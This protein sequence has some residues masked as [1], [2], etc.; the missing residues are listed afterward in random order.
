MMTV[1]ETCPRCGAGLPGELLDGLCESCLLR[2]S[3]GIGSPPPLSDDAAGAS[4]FDLLDP[5]LPETARVF[6]DYELLE[7]L[8]AGGMGIVWRARQRT[9]NRFVAIKMIRAGQLARPEDVARF[10]NEAEAVARLRHP[11]IVAIHEVGEVDAQH[12]FSMDLAPGLSLSQLLHD[13]PLMPR[14]AATILQRLCLAIQHAHERGVIHRDLK[15][16]NILLDDHDQPHITDF[17]L[18]RLAE[19]ASD[20]TRTDAIVGS[21]GYMAPEQAAGRNRDVDARTDL[22]AL[23][24]IL[25]ELLTGRPPYQAGSAMAT[26]K[27]VVESEPVPPRL[28]NPILPRDLDTI[29]LK[30]LEKEPAKRYPTAQALADDLEHF[31]NDESILARPVTR[32]ERAARWCRR[33]P[34][35]AS[36]S[37]LILLLLV[38]VIVGSPIAAYRINEARRQAT[39]EADTARAMLSFLRDDLLSVA[40]PFAGNTE[41]PR[42]RN[43]TLL[44]AVDL[45]ARNVRQRF[46]D[47]PLVEAGIR[48]TLW[49]VYFALGD[50]DRAEEH[51]QSAL[52]LYNQSPGAPELERLKALESMAWMHHARGRY[53]EAT[54]LIEPVLERR[55]RLQGAD[56]PEVLSAQRCRLAILSSSSR[57]P[58]AIA[59]G[60]DLLERARQLPVEHTEVL[61]R[62]MT[63]MSWMEYIDGDFPRCHALAE[64]AL[65]IARSRLGEGH[66][67]TLELKFGWA[68]WL[69]LHLGRVY[70]AT[71]LQQEAYDRAREILGETHELTLNSLSELAWLADAKG[72]FGRKM[73]IQE[74]LVPLARQA[75]G[76]D[77]PNAIFE[78]MRLGWGR[79]EE[80]RLDDADAVLTQAL[81]GLR[82]SRGSDD[83]LARRAMRWLS[84][85]HIARAS[86]PEAITLRKA[87]LELERRVTGLDAPWTHFET[88]HLA[89]LHARLGQWP[90]SAKLFREFLPNWDPA[91]QRGRKRDSLH[92]AGYVTACLAGDSIIAREIAA[93]ALQRVERNEDW[94]TRYEIALAL[95]LAPQFVTAHS[96]LLTL[97]SSLIESSSD[98]RE[99]DLLAAVLAYRQSEFDRSAILL[100]AIADNTSTAGGLASAFLSMAHHRLGIDTALDECN[101]AREFVE[102]LTRAGELGHSIF[103]PEEEWLPAA[104]LILAGREAEI[105][106]HG[107]PIQPQFDEFTMANA[108][109]R[110]L[111][112]RTLLDDV[113]RAANRGDWP[114][115]LEPF[116]AAIDQEYFDW[117]A[118]AQSREHFAAKAAALLA[119]DGKLN[120][121]PE[122]SGRILHSSH[123]AGSLNGRMFLLLQ[124]ESL[125]PTTI[126]SLVTAARAAAQDGQEVDGGNPWWSLELGLAELRAGNPQAALNALEPAVATY[127]LRCAAAAHAVAALAYWQL[128]DPDLARQRLVQART[129]YQELSSG[130]RQSLGNRWHEIIGVHLALQ[131]ATEVLG[132]GGQ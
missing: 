41:R 36:A 52:D 6:G 90:E 129:T 83:F 89:N 75:F 73:E 78:Q 74:S 11:G 96:E 18:A 19:N 94:Q 65:G 84:G 97:A 79:L 60:E 34:A 82:K 13:G 28:L 25:Y 132:W 120:A 81:D 109:E 15:P 118:A 8:G 40:D 51:I 95:L 30:C 107:Q 27:L 39:Q 20:L 47:Q 55:T 76:P 45:A 29:C 88:Y 98:S 62:I 31:L 53:A 124:D 92:P 14:R 24:A 17:G 125:S 63:D 77:S 105:F 56:H 32:V 4:L 117:S 44:A 122:L 49:Q 37:L 113:D 9:L 23:G 102:R 86:Y 119:L 22:H 103:Y 66:A 59:L 85:V 21:P 123:G 101:R 16:S 54:A 116:L 121:I 5:S 110:W 126:E 69:R 131:K 127:N 26:L 70:D 1:S 58:E 72:L 57:Q 67:L 33:K 108:R 64:E 50:L 7:E 130:N 115:A 87:I 104:M 80:G 99:K 61:L 43:L 111:P 68:V 114:T 42:G 46:P 128:G 91:K 10:R 100:T 71:I 2:F 38:I 48:V 93:L 35:L 12:F 112:I 106:V 3:L